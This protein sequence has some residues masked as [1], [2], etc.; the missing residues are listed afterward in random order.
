MSFS[1]HGL[2][3][4]ETYNIIH[5]LCL[6]SVRRFK[7]AQFSPRLCTL[8]LVS[9]LVKPEKLDLE[10]GIE[11]EKISGLTFLDVSYVLPLLWV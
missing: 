4:I 5:N 8:T 1:Q 7:P 3:E 9:A 2:L 6:W 10:E 11:R